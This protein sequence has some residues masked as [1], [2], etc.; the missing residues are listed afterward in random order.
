MLDYVKLVVKS[1][2]HNYFGFLLSISPISSC[3][4][5]SVLSMYVSLI[6]FFLKCMAID[7]EMK[8]HRVSILNFVNKLM[9]KS[10]HGSLHV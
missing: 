10:V 2:Q 6:I 5:S 4:V 7:F 8:T 9:A 1:K 3:S